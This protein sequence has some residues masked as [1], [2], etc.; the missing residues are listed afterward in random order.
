M[1]QYLMGHSDIS[2]NLNTYSHLKPDYATEVLENM[3]VEKAEADRELKE[4]GDFT[5]IEGQNIPKKTE[6]RRKTEKS[7][8]KDID[9]KTLI[10]QDKLRYTEINFK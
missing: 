7:G 1:L 8:K 10:L 5:P 2:V 4:I 9:L 6:I 3:A